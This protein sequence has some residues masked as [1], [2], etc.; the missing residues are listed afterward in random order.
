MVTEIPVYAMQGHPF[1][2][3]SAFIHPCSLG[4][5]ADIFF[6]RPQGRWC[7]SLSTAMGTA[8]QE[9]VSGG[10]LF[11]TYTR[12]DPAIRRIFLLRAD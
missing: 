12:T 7:Y 9:N 10:E 11:L 8:A 6:A 1:L 3:A 2:T 5:D 4:R